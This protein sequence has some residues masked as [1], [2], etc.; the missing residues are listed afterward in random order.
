MRGLR[1]LAALLG[2]LA[3]LVMGM[4]APAVAVPDL[5]DGRYEGT[6]SQGRSV[7][8]ELDG[9]APFLCRH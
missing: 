7:Y 8:F 5:Q 4:A 1:S 9:A 3:L 2:A 6:T